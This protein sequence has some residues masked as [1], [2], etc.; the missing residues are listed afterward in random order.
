MIW[1]EHASLAPYNTFGIDAKAERLV[2]LETEASL[3]EYRLHPQGYV[4]QS[5]LL[6]GGVTCCS[7][8]MYP[9]PRP[10]LL[11]PV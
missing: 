4:K 11:G 3:A 10:E 6:S 5:L 8:Q 1:E 7:A 9:A 2:H